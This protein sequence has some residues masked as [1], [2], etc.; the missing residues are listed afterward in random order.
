MDR[1]IIKFVVE[2]RFCCRHVLYGNL[3]NFPPY[4]LHEPKNVV[5][6]NI[7]LSVS[8]TTLGILYKKKMFL[9]ATV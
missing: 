5:K 6:T 9:T 7:L 1:S 2:I 3:F 4:S 8:P